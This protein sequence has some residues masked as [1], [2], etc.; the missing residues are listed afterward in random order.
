MEE[1]I[2]KGAEGPLE[3]LDQDQTRRQLLRW[4]TVTALNNSIL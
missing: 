1:S 3:E 2:I 4:V